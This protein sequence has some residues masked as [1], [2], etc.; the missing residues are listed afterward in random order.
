MNTRLSMRELATYLSGL[1]AFAGVTV[2]TIYATRYMKDVYTAMPA[3]WIMGQNATREDDGRGYSGRARQRM[4]VQIAIRIVVP[5]IVENVP[6]AEPALTALQN[7]VSDALFGWM[8][9]GAEDHFVWVSASE[10]R[11]FDTVVTSVL[12]FSST[13]VFTA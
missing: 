8:P 7:A 10:G 1:P 2:D 11:T 4:R 12:T 3:V 6:D 9:D 13:V 5:R